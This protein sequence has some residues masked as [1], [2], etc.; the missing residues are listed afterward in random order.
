MPQNAASWNDR[1][2]LWLSIAAFA[3]L[4]SLLFCDS[5][6]PALAEDFSTTPGQAA[7]VISAFAI[8]YGALQIFYGPM[9]D[10]YGKFKVVAAATLACTVG[11]AAAA[12]S[13]TLD[14]LSASRAL[15]GATAAGIIPLT[16]AWIGDNVPYA[17]RQEILARLLTSTVSGMI[18]GQWLGGLIADTLGWRMGFA[19]LAAL[20][21]IASGLMYIE[22][23]K[24]RPQTE[25]PT[26]TAGSATSRMLSVLR[27][28]W[29][30]RILFITM[31]E[32]AVAYSAVS[33]VPNHLHMQFGLSMGSAGAVLALFGVGGLLYS[34]L[35][36]KLVLRL[37]EA[38]LAGL[39]GCLLATSFGLLAWMP[40]WQWALPACLLGGF[41]FYCLHNTLQTQATQMVQAARGTAVSLFACFLFLGQSAGI[42]AAS[43]VIDAYS[44]IPVFIAAAASILVLGIGF[45][46]LL[47]KGHGAR[48]A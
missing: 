28:P 26:I 15:S 2:L 14:W 27:V 45:A 40:V 9:G 47:N 23:H 33:F 20:F 18:A 34:R 36:K 6:L 29:A 30:R 35:A 4:A 19:M 16:M 42:F 31:V 7:L 17:R 10:R 21:A 43:L 24:A 38:S 39:G 32:G 11:S 8:A 25:H 41:S 3:S 44:A 13:P 22:L 37:G 12:I 46:L 5:M 1:T 48:S